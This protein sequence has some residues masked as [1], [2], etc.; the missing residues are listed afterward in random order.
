MQVKFDNHFFVVACCWC[1]YYFIN[2]AGHQHTTHCP[3]MASV[4]QAAPSLLT[5][6]VDTLFEQHS[7]ADIDKIHKKL[8]NDVEEKKE[9]LRTMV[10]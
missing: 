6:N 2:Q 4:A 3:T 7:I 5:I 8:Q 1:F 9:E 10:G